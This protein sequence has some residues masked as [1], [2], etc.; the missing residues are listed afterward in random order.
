LDKIDLELRQ[1]NRDALINND[2][3]AGKLRAALLTERKECEDRD[4]S[5]ADVLAETRPGSP[6]RKLPRRGARTPRTRQRAVL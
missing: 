3:A 2:E 1:V 5:L 4:E 6:R